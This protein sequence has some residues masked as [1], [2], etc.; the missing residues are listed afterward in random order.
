[1]TLAPVIKKVCINNTKTSSKNPSLPV[2][3]QEQSHCTTSLVVESCWYII[4]P[5]GTYNV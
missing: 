3:K 4:L 2:D 1:M 5:I